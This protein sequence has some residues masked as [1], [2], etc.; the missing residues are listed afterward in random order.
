MCSS[1]YVG[2]LSWAA[3]VCGFVGACCVKGNWEVPSLVVA[4]QSQGPGVLWY[5]VGLAM[6]VP[7]GTMPWCWLDPGSV[8][9]GKMRYILSAVTVLHSDSGS[10]MQAVFMRWWSSS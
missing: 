7:A 5:E 3:V 1:V 2:G 6:V 8:C 10:D 9:G 4:P